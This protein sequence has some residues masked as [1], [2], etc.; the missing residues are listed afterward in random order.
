M[1]AL[2]A[3]GLSANVVLGPLGVGL[4]KW[5]VSL[6]GLN[7]TYG[8]DGAS[9]LL[10]VPAALV[11]AR[12][13]S[14]G[15]PLAA[16]LAL[17]VGLATV[18]YAIA[19]TLGG[20]YLRYPG[21]NERFFLLFLLLIV[22]SWTIAVH[23]WSSLD[24]EPPLPA[25]WL[26]RAFG[27]LSVLAAAFLGVAWIAQLVP[28][29]LTGVVG[30]DYLDSPSAFWTIRIVDLGFIVPI[31]AWTGVG[32]WR[33]QATAIRA[34]YGLAAFLM[35]QG[36]SVLAM[37]IIMLWRADPTASA[38]FVYVLAPIVAALAT[39]TAWLFRSYAVGSSRAGR[40]DT[41]RR[42]H[43]APTAAQGTG[44]DRQRPATSSST[45]I[46]RHAVTR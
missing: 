29:A 17:G 15:H 18:Y 41:A 33:Q 37:G 23:A 11:A 8:A 32:L 14:V 20:D 38:T 31:T 36:A 13:W 22:L 21:N 5:R 45:R 39:L 28:I 26:R 2:L 46:R 3:A 25:A 42:L 35:L 40:G 12:L 27:T 34:A 4:L 19:E 44:T 10:V 43:T 16:P 9:L 6:N 1:L 30:P 7:Q 24:A